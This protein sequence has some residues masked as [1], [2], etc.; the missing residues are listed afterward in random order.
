MT[1]EGK[2]E[3]DSGDDTDSNMVALCWVLNS[4][5]GSNHEHMA[6]YMWPYMDSF[7]PT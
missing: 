6:Q 4:S 1:A 2:R 3:G 7:S 5:Y